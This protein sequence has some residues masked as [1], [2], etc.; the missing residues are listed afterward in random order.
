MST[1]TELC[2]FTFHLDINLIILVINF[3]FLML[4]LFLIFGICLPRPYMTDWSFTQ[5]A[6]SLTA[7]LQM[8]S[9]DTPVDEVLDPV[10]EG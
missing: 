8:C 2:L 9:C 5:S 3:I 1:R 4:L 10:L 7:H 6:L